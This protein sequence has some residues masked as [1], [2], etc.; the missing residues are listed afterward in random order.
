MEF[1][2]PCYLCTEVNDDST[3]DPAVKLDKRKVFANESSIRQSEFFQSYA[4]GLKPE[5]TLK[6]RSFEYKG[7][8]I[9]EYKDIE[10]RVLRSYDT[11]KG[12]VELVLHK[13]V[14]NGNSK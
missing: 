13:G 11:K 9:V 8:K 5:V 4:L 2:Y 3:P 10:Y 6:V 1:I 7:E 12:Y 14:N